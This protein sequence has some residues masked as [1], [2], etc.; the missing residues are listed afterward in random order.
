MEWIN[1]K[2]YLPK[3]KGYY[4]TVVDENVASKRQGVVEIQEL[5]QSV[6]NREV[7]LKFQDYV[8]HW[9]PI[10]EPPELLNP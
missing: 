1:V 6:K 10:P 2:D 7:V 5:Y 9:M 8:T 3:V 4:L